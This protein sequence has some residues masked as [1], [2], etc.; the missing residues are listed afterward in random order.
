MV[1]HDINMTF[2]SV[3]FQVMGDGGK[4]GETV[5]NQLEGATLGGGVESEDESKEELR[6]IPGDSKNMDFCL[7]VRAKIRP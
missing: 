7:K 5:L 4:L 6:E 1:R 2:D 3:F